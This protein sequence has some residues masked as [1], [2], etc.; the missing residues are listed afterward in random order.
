[1]TSPGAVCYRGV[2][3]TVTFRAAAEPAASRRDYWQHVVSTAIGPVD[4]QVLGDV[5]DRDRLVVGD[6]GAVRV[7]ALDA[8]YPGG[9]SRRARHIRLADPD[10][11]KIDVVARGNGVVE[12][13]GREAVLR[14]GDLTFVDLSRPGHWRM[15]P[16]RLIA[17]IFPRTLLPLRRD[18]V[19]RLTAV[20]IPGDRGT[21]ALVSSL[22]RDLVRHL[23]DAEPGEAVRLGTAVL[24]LFTAALAGRLDRPAPQ[25]EGRRAMLARVQA[26]IGEH[27]ADPSLSPRTIADAHFIS[28]RYLH[29]LFEAEEATVA[30]SIRHRRLERCR[31]DLLDPGLRDRPVSAIATRWGMPNASHFSRAFRDAYG[32]PPAELRALGVDGTTS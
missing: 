21:G 15:S 24:D 9:A 17:I 2:M 27:L 31:R 10:V 14:A 28:V 23:G 26:Y 3:G 7:G 19:D 16:A 32:V 11:C 8:S 6:L 12:Q 25:P 13:D 1:M 30:G 18:E 20:R 22:A 29:R 5:G 4:L